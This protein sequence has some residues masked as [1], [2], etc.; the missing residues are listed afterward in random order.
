MAA[1][2]A[3]WRNGLSD[4]GHSHRPWSPHDL[5]ADNKQESFMKG[6]LLD[7]NPWLR[8]PGRRAEL[9]RVSV[10]SSSAIEGIV[11]PFREKATSTVTRPARQRAKSEPTRG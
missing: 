7:S 2:L 5:A 3:Y 6:S 1:G 11:K 9:M 8:E 4:P 10:A